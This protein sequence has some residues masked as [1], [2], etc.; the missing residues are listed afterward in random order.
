MS[1]LGKN[2]TFLITPHSHKWAVKHYSVDTFYGDNETSCPSGIELE[3]SAVSASLN[4][5]VHLETRTNFTELMAT[6]ELTAIYY[7]HR[8]ADATLAVLQDTGNYKCNYTLAQPLVWGHPESIDE[9]YIKD[10]ATGPPQLV[11]PDEY[12][13]NEN[14]TD[15]TGFDFSYFKSRQY[16]SSK[17]CSSWHYRPF[18]DGE[19]FYNPKHYERV[20]KEFYD[21]ADFKETL[22]QC[23]KGTALLPSIYKYEYTQMDQKEKLNCSE[24]KCNGFESFSMNLIINETTNKTV[25]CSKSNIGQEFN[26]T[27][28]I[29]KCPDPERFCRTMRLNEGYFKNDPFDMN[30]KFFGENEEPTKKSKKNI[31]VECVIAAVL[32]IVIVIIS[33][34]IYLKIK[35]AKEAETVN[36]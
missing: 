33:I 13:S 26:T 1:N 32:V 20:G 21:Y 7:N 28:F 14:N 9:N 17:N 15:Y 25:E 31:I 12:I 8:L 16:A 19:K 18:C 6:N 10:F 29:L 35:K 3:V 23:P 34:I 11:F 36:I 4:N 24:Y 5:V 22:Y 27:E 2:F 30:T